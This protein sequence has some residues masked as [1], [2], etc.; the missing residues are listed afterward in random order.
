MTRSALS[1]VG[2]MAS[3]QGGDHACCISSFTRQD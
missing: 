3:K 2:K 1:W